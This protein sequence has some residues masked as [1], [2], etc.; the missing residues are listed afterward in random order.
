MIWIIIVV[1][2]NSIDFVNQ[3]RI[4]AAKNMLTS[5][6]Y[7]QYTIIAIA[8]EAGFN[9][10]ASFNRIVKKITGKSPKFLKKSH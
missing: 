3:Y 9:S 1:F 8:Y 5:D 4:E 7:N 2:F 10:K 6:K